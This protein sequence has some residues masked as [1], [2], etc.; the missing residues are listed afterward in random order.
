[1]AFSAVLSSIMRV[2]DLIF[3]LV[4]LLFV[5]RAVLQLFKVSFQNPFMRGVVLITDPLLNLTRR[6]L[7]LSSY[8]YSLPINVNSDFLA[9]LAT[10]IGL[11]ALRTVLNWVF[12]LILFVPR[13]FVDPL[14]TTGTLVLFLLRI[15]FDLY[16]LA[17]LL[18]IVFEWLR[19]S[20]TS[21]IMRFLWTI[22]EP[23]L[24]AI[25]GVIPPFAGLDFSPLIAFFLLRLLEQ[26]IFAMIF[27]VF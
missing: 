10:I 15:L 26:I 25:R 7:G 3:G 2:L 8:R 9:L 4:G 14:T 18:R 23:L 17:L 1:M 16:G 5:L 13:L 27:W 19:V 11:W 6:L 21:P 12:Q 22:T 20:Y 24:A